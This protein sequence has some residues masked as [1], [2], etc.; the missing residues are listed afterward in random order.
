MGS[1]PEVIVGKAWRLLWDWP[2]GTLGAILTLRTCL[3]EAA[4]GGSGLGFFSKIFGLVIGVSLAFTAGSLLLVASFFIARPL[5]IM[6]VTKY[7]GVL[8][9]NWP[10]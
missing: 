3:L 6:P 4:V 7:L 9:Y 1:F 10:Y 2:L 8:I 5:V